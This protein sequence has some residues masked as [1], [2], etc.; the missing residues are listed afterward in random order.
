[1]RI[2]DFTGAIKSFIIALHLT[3]GLS[4]L[5]GRIVIDFNSYIKYSYARCSYDD[6]YNFSSL[7]S[8]WSEMPSPRGCECE[9]CVASI[10]RE[11]R[12]PPVFDFVNVSDAKTHG[13]PQMHFL[14]DYILRGYALKEQ[15]FCECS[16]CELSLRIS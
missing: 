12:Q 9:R 11:T 6:H 3:D 4:Q 15:K 16:H 8:T 2:H 13:D 1:M 7:S 10:Y 5:N 14:S